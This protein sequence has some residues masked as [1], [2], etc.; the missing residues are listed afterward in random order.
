LRR[1]SSLIP[2]F[3]IAVSGDYVEAAQ[4]PNT[5]T[6]EIFDFVVEA[7]SWDEAARE[8]IS[9]WRANTGAGGDPKYL[10]PVPD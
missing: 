7:G 3:R 4:T 9:R 8:A 6:P 10:Q 2:T 1:W 5:P